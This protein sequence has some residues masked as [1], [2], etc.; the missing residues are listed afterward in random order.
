MHARVHVIASRLAGKPY[1]IAWFMDNERHH[2][3]LPRFVYSPHCA[4]ALR[5]FLETKYSTIAGLNSAW[6]STYAS[7]D[8]FPSK[9]PEPG[10]RGTAQFA[11]YHAFSRVLVKRYVDSILSA[12]HREDPGRLVFSNR[13]M[14]GEPRD[15]FDYLDLYAGCDGIAINLYP[16]NIHP[17][18]GPEERAL[19]E[20]VNRRTHKPIVISEWSVPSAGQRLLQRPQ[21]LGQFRA[22]GGRNAIAARLP[23]IAGH[24]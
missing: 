19:L 14:L 6:G 21:K 18:L 24:R 11:D 3:D 7:F 8:D 13:F 23:G 20:E 4:A 16:S 10:P 12:I 9:K 17:G 2:R 5:Q 15:L 22:G 1:L